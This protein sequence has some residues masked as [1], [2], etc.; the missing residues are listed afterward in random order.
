MLT[1]KLDSNEDQLKTYLELMDRGENRALKYMD[2]QRGDDGHVEIDPE[3]PWASLA[4]QTASKGVN[5]LIDIFKAG[6]PA[7]QEM[8]AQRIGKQREAVTRQDL[9]VLADELKHVEPLR[10]QQS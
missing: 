5:A 6:A 2:M 1:K 3:H 8:I 7:F 10:P 9:T 4:V